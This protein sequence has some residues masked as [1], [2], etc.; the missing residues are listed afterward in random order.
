M[1]AKALTWL[2][3]V[4][5]CAVGCAHTR[6]PAPVL[7]PVVP[8]SFRVQVT[9]VGKPML[10]IPGL[11]CSG[12]VWDDT[13]AHYKDRYQIH[14]LTLAGFAGLPAVQ[15]PFM[16]TV[17]RDVIAYIA[18]QQ[19]DHPV[20]VGHSLGG[21]LAFWVAATAP[22]RVGAVVAVDGVP[23]LPAL[24]KDNA[25]AENSRAGADRVRASVAG[26]SSEQFAAQNHATLV[27]WIKD[28]KQVERVAARSA[29]SD[30]TAVA[31]AMFELMTTDLRPIVATLTVPA[32]L[33]AASGDEPDTTAVIARY[34]SQIASMP[35]HRTVAAPTR[36]FVML[37]DAAFL[38]A[39][40]DAFL[41]Q[42]RE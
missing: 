16:D 11:T 24:F 22:D 1:T 5:A 12:D 7:A 35:H 28:P 27:A 23:F 3:L 38:H 15:P 17:R 40:M 34:E 31:E 2:W 37:D 4:A 21:F 32:L 13:V 14:V 39:Q 8:R 25:T 41:S 36:H 10:L 30:P 9:G 26:L 6:A 20:L 29:K 33:V 18:E 19:L 42:G